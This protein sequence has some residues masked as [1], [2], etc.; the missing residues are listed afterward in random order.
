MKRDEKGQFVKKEDK[1]EDID[2]QTD[3]PPSGPD[4]KA[5][6][7]TGTRQPME[8]L[9]QVAADAKK[10]Q[11]PTQKKKG[12]KKKRGP[13]RP[14]KKPVPPEPEPPEFDVD[15]AMMKQGIKTLSA[16]AAR[17]RGQHWLLTDEEVETLAQVS[18]AMAKKYFPLMGPW[19]VELNFFGALLLILGPRLYADYLGRQQAKKVDEKNETPTE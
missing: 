16:I 5:G 19:M 8:T 7:D 13:G 12:A 1:K 11:K 3:T 9:E 18:D 15:A 14:R 17:H 4:E 6:N 10:S 2:K